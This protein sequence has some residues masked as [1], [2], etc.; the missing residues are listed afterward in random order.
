VDFLHR[1]RE[2]GFRRRWPR[3]AVRVSPLA[4]LFLAALTLPLAAQI[5]PAPS[6]NQP[7]EPLRLTLTIPL[8]QPQVSM[9]T[10]LV[11]P[12]GPGPFPLA[13]INHGSAESAELR[14]A[15]VQ[16]SYDSAVQWF[17]AR[18]YAVAL[19]LRPGHGRAGGPYL[20]SNG[21]CAN[22]D[23]RKAGLATADSIEAAIRFLL[24]RPFLRKTGVVV[25]GHSAGG[26]GALALA[27][28]NPREVSA[29]IAFAPGRG[30][31]INGRPNSNCAPERLVEA[32]RGF[33]ATARVP[34]LSIVAI[35][36]TVIG[37]DLARRLTAAYRDAG[38][39]IDFRLL[40]AFGNEGHALFEQGMD[41]W[42]P[43]V[44]EFLKPRK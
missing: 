18:G 42:A 6:G 3:R 11:R 20:E 22:P 27:G 41:L 39:R 30:G 25:V 33:G 31:R 7:G 13:V 4:A 24:T 43:L 37:P 38:G 10:I 12:Q 16:P 44:E 1:K 26:F 34:V 14:A 17:V 29:I 9:P 23:F 2:T 36:D 21:P 40:P 32:A 8:P 19:P 35:N 5:A 15:F 28:R